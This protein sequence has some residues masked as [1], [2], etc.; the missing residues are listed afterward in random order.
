[1]S[2]LVIALLLLAVSVLMLL[3]PVTVVSHTQHGRSYRFFAIL[4]VQVLPVF[5]VTAFFQYSETHLQIPL[6]SF[7]RP[8]RSAVFSV[9][10]ALQFVAT[11]VVLRAYDGSFVKKAAYIAGASV[12]AVGVAVIALGVISCLNGN[13][14]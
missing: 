6:L 12:G 5:L 1:M 2:A 14:F 3:A 4:L 13:C 10:A 9:V 7:E 11:T 8:S